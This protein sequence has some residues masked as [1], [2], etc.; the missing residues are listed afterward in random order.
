MGINICPLWF[1]KM[2]YTAISGKDQKLLTQQKK[3]KFILLSTI[4]SVQNSQINRN[5][6]GIYPAKQFKTFKI[7]HPPKWS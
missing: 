2:S 3:T 4:K 6:Q 7:P 5:Y 1:R